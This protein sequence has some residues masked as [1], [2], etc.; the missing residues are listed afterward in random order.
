MSLVGLGASFRFLRDPRARSDDRRAPAV[1]GPVSSDAAAGAASSTTVPD[2]CTDVT[3]TGSGAFFFAGFG[4]F[5]TIG[6]DN[7]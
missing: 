2:D 6:Y 4:F 5:A 7:S 3:T 1:R